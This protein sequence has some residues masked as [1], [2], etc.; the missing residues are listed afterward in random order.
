[1]IKVGMNLLLWSDNANYRE[2]HHLLDFCKEVGFDGVEFH[3]GI[4]SDFEECEKFGAHARELGLGV[5]TVGVFDPNVCNPVSPDPALRARVY[6]EFKKFIDATLTLGGTL[7][8]GPLYQGLGYFSGARA[9]EE[10]WRMSVETMRPCFEYA[11]K[12]GIQ[13]AVEP[14][15]RFEAYLVNTVAD[16]V[17]YVKD[18]GLD[19]VGLLVDTMHSNIEELDIARAYREAMPHIKHVHISEND[20]GIPGTGHACGK[21]VFDA[22]KDFGYGGYL[23]IEAFNLGAPSLMGALHL[24]RT[25]AKS[26]DQLAKQGHDYI[27]EMLKS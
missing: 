15:N 6:P 24:W 13:V 2:H 12:A 8:C 1:M 26:D 7:I 10:E 17:R 23:T 27:R 19:N 14:L 25:F 16:G 22:F 3:V 11:R 9:T 21:E 18:I 20:R 5:T 4:V